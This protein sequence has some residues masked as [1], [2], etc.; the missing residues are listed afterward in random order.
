MSQNSKTSTVTVLSPQGLHARP[1]AL[2]V[3]LIG[4]F[5]SSVF[6]QKNAGERVDCRSILS[7]LTLGAEQGVELKVTVEGEDAA[8][9]LV[10]VEQLFSCGFHE[11]DSTPGTEQAVDS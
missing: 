11:V 2:L 6:L 5:K 4:S 3:K 10:A 1:A 9:T 8:E 7:L